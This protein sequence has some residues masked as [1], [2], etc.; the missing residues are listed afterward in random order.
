MR[1]LNHQISVSSRFSTSS[2]IIFFRAHFF[3]TLMLIILS[4]AWEALANNSKDHN[5]FFPDSPHGGYAL[6]RH[7]TV[8][9]GKMRQETSDSEGKSFPPSLLTHLNWNMVFL[10]H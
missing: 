6:K 2:N 5:S 8:L 3:C 1:V 7:G 10:F 4:S 9:N